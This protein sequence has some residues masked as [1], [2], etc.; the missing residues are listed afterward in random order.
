[1]GE[2]RQTVNV[3]RPIEAP[4]RRQLLE[5]LEALFA[6]PVTARALRGGGEDMLVVADGHPLLI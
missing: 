6:Q 5:S 1:V 3:I 2:L 4:L